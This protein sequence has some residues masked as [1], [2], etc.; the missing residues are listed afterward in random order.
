MP[1]FFLWSLCAVMALAILPCR[2]QLFEMPYQYGSREVNCAE[3][4][5]N[6]RLLALSQRLAVEALKNFPE[7][8]AADRAMLLKAAADRASGNFVLAD[9][10]LQQFLLKRPNSPLISAAQYERGLMAFEQEKYENAMQ[11]FQEAEHSS[12]TS[13]LERRDSAYHRLGAEASFWSAASAAKLG[14]IDEAINLFNKMSLNYSESCFADDALYAAGELNDVA[15]RPIEAIPFYRK[16][17][18]NYARRNTI[19][20]A[21]IREADDQLLLRNPQM[22]LGL[23]EEAEYTLNS[24]ENDTTSIL[25]ERQ[26]Y[27]ENSRENIGYLRGE[28]L[29]AAGQYERSLNT[30][31][32]VLQQY[33]GSYL[34]LQMKLGQG[35]SLLNLGRYKEAESIY[36][37]VIDS[38]GDAAESRATALL[39]H[40]VVQKYMGNREQAIKE[41]TA[42]SLQADFPY[43]AQALLEAGQIHYEDKQYD[44]ARKSFERAERETNDAVTSAR[45]L[46]LLG[47]SQLETE[48]Y[49]KSVRSLSAAE[50][51]IVNSNDTVMSLRMRH[52]AEAR[53]YQGIALAENNQYREAIAKLGIFISEHAKDERKDEAL[54]WIAEASYRSELFKNAQDFYEETLEQYPK[55]QRIEEALYG[56]GWTFFRQSEFAKSAAKFSDLVRRFP[57]SRF[58]ADAMARKGDGHFIMKQYNDAAASYR[59]ALKYSPKTEEGQYAAYQMGYAYF[60]GNDLSH[61][62]DAFRT[63]VRSYPRS[64]FAPAAL[65]S[66]GWTYFQQQNYS[67]AITAFNNLI[68]TYPDN[69]LLARA[70]YSIGDCYYNSGNFEQAI[71]AYRVVTA[72]FP[73]SP[74]AGEA[75][76]SM[77]FCLEALGR[78]AEADSV[79]D[80]YARNNPTLEVTKE[81]I[82]TKA[83]KFYS[84]GRYA[85][86]VTE[87]EGFMSK[88]PDDDKKAEALYYLG[89]SYI[90]MN[91][92]AKAE[93]SLNN[94]EKKYPNSEFASLG[95]LEI[96]YLKLQQNLPSAADSVFRI[97]QNDYAATA[98]A[99]QAGFERAEIAYKRGDTIKS[100]LLYR[101]IAERYRATEYGDQSLYRAAMYYRMKNITDSSRNFFTELAARTNNPLIA[102]EAYYRIGELWMRQKSYD[103]ALTAFVVI[104]EK[105]SEVEDWFTLSMLAA[106][107]C[108]EQLQN[109]EAARTSYQ[110]IVALRPDDDY[111]K[112]AA[113]RL[114]RL[115]KETVKKP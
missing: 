57:D 48:Q 78:D 26:D 1:Q 113:A 33:P 84:S 104:R 111:G 13:L 46:I 45:V 9:A 108:Y 96:A 110:T 16:I 55:S 52:L 67:D 53:L 99:P 89:K 100:L 91:E 6:Q 102:A 64:R 71:A 56:L 14:R 2:A 87:L 50:K 66:L 88:Y 103:S 5:F 8:P 49:A 47:L 29:N 73:S 10:G 61:A 24:S 38:A 4:R 79:V 32:I 37:Q 31:N 58:A 20:A 106:G 65:Y 39:Y 62:A 93:L 22:A 40:A 35:W 114:R 68:Q 44:Q 101:D 105:Y 94:I 30:F 41:F 17:R 83:Q 42:L 82:T 98:Q 107:E 86:A 74:Y 59:L 25:Y 3:K 36:R 80:E 60:R 81:L 21:L 19:S 90:G 63:F 112:T 28:A 18:E 15:N 34:A 109:I 95:Q 69:E 92:P 70:H 7:S 54:F 115:P 43:T 97:V 27:N 72:S 75:I 11:Y 12:T 85:N 51:L 23:L 76:K 77:Q